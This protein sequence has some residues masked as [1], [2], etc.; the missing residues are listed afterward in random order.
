MGWC[1]QKGNCRGSILGCVQD[2]KAGN[3]REKKKDEPEN[4]ALG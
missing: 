2:E 3:E 4:Q 1:V